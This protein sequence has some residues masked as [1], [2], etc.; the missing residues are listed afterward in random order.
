ML[1]TVAIA[2]A[3][4]LGLTACSTPAPRVIQTNSDIPEIR[5]MVGMA[6][7]IEIPADGRVKTLTVGNPAL[8]T[9]TNSADVV[10]LLAAGEAGETNLI[11]RSSDADGKTK[12]YQYRIVVGR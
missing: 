11:I 12:V 10:S 1:K 3:A 4:L 5:L 8:V 7:Q 9:A 2:I 6:T